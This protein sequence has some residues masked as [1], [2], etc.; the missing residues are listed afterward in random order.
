MY[1]NI[2]DNAHIFWDYHGFSYQWIKTLTA[3]FAATCGLLAAYPY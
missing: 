3:S 1:D 2:I